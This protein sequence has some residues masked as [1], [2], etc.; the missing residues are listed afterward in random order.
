MAICTY[1]YMSDI[2]HN[3]A[4]KLSTYSTTSVKQHKL[5][6]RVLR[7]YILNLIVLYIILN[8]IFNISLWTIISISTV[9]YNPCSIDWTILLI[10]VAVNMSMCL[11]PILWY[12]QWERWEQDQSG[13]RKRGREEE[14]E[15]VSLCVCVCV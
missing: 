12:Q 2:L 7:V 15:R 14:R 4:F 13:K 6:R 9:L 1:A 5:D 8:I 3:T 10:F 11:P